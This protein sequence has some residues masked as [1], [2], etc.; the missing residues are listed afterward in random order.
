MDI[1]AYTHQIRYYINGKRTGADAWFIAPVMS[2]E[3]LVL[4]T[5]NMRKQ[6]DIS[7][8]MDVYGCMKG[9]DMTDCCQ[10]VPEAVY[11]INYVKTINN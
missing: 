11:F 6:P 5:G 3:K 9:E 7:C 10:K 4:R 1:D 8:D 2:V